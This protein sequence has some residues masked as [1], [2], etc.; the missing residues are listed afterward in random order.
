MISWPPGVSA[1]FHVAET[2]SGQKFVVLCALNIKQITNIL[3]Y[4]LYM[5]ASNI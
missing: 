3:N 5:N 1:W 4:Q 2:H